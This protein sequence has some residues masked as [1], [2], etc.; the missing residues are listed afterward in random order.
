MHF[1]IRIAYLFSFTRV[2]DGTNHVSA[3]GRQSQEDEKR[4]GEERR[5]CADPH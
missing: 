3:G 1:P 5:E 4:D 2:K